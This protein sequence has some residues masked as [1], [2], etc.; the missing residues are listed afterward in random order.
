MN[1]KPILFHYFLI[2][3]NVFLPW[4]VVSWVGIALSYYARNR[5]LELKSSYVAFPKAHESWTNIALGVFI[6]YF[7]LSV[8]R[9]YAGYLGL[10]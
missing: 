5:L 1:K 9:A 3:I 10:I 2:P 4:S 8:A 6:I 7:L